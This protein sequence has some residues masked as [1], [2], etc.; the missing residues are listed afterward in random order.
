MAEFDVINNETKVTE[1]VYK[2][3]VSTLCSVGKQPFTGK[4]MVRY[5]PNK[6][7]LEFES[8]DEWLKSFGD[9]TYTIESLTS[10]IFTMIDHY[11]EPMRLLVEVDAVTL[12]HGP[13]KAIRQEGY[14]QGLGMTG[15]EIMEL[16]KEMG[17]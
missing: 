5:E 1:V 2:Q 10:F 4:L 9:K 6:R 12:V 13:A 14:S 16:I 15:R 7:L 17:D 8:F 3:M 11:V